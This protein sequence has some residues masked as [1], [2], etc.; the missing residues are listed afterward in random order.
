MYMRVPRWFQRPQE[1]L[2]LLELEQH[3]VVKYTGARTQT[4]ALWKAS[5]FS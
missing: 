5:L 3:E 2:N 1:N 4:L